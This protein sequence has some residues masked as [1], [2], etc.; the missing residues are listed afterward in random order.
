MKGRLETD[1][2]IALRPDI[3][4]VERHNS[5]QL[6]ENAAGACYATAVTPLLVGAIGPSRRRSGGMDTSRALNAPTEEQGKRESLVTRP[7]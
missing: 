5:A 3:S 4:I 1:I 6:L 2:S 7:E